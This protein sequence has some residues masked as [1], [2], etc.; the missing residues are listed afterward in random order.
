MYM[1]RSYQ[2]YGW[3]NVKSDSIARKGE[4]F[5]TIDKKTIHLKCLQAKLS[6]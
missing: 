3:I 2:D 6:R 5:F 1:N 4:M